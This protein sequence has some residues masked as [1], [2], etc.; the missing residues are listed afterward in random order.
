MS[1][2]RNYGPDYRQDF[3]TALKWGRISHT[4][5]TYWGS[6]KCQVARVRRKGETVYGFR[7]FEGNVC[8]LVSS[9]PYRTIRAAMLFCERAVDSI[10]FGHYNITPP[11]PRLIE[12]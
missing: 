7:V 6:F 5:I 9:I 8:V 4:Y 1:A 3:G 10:G 12:V 11:I 2:N